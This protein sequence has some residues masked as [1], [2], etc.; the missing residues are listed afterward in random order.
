MVLLQ[1]TKKSV[2]NEKLA[3]S[4]WAGEMMDFMAVDSAGA[5]RGTLYHSFQCVVVHV[6]G[7]N[8]AIKRKEVWD[9][10]GD[11]NEIQRISE[12]KWCSRMDRGMREFNAMIDQLELRLDVFSDHSPILLM[13]DDRDW[14]PRSFKFI[15]AWLLHPSFMKWN[16]E[17]FG[18]VEFKLK[19]I[20]EELHTLDLRAEEGSLSSS[21]AA[22]RREAKGEA[23]QLSKMVEWVW[24]QKSR[25]NWAIKGDRN[26]KKIHIMACSKKNGNALCSIVING[27]VVENPQDVRA[28]VKNH[29]LNHFSDSWCSRPV[30]LGPF[31]TIGEDQSSEFWN[32]FFQ[33]LK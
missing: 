10:L 24:L 20:E 2:S 31:N 30:L 19:Q 15:N 8:D 6:Y 33:N 17:V 22:R 29:F 3:R 1:E 12:R 25:L 28:E 14:G 5:A 27:S 26:T 16:N 23:W 4:I 9:I 7:P 21:Q 32:Q 11:F 18:H 13:E